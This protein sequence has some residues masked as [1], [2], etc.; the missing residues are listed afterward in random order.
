MALPRMWGPRNSSPV[1]GRRGQSSLLP[2]AGHNGSQGIMALHATVVSTWAMFDRQ[3]P[4][5]DSVSHD[6]LEIFQWAAQVEGILARQSVEDGED[7]AF[8]WGGVCCLRLGWRGWRLYW[9]GHHAVCWR[10]GGLG[11]PESIE[12]V[13]W[14]ADSQGPDV[15]APVE[16]FDCC[17]VEDA[18]LNRAQGHSG[19]EE[20][21]KAAPGGFRQT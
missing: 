11:C 6:L 17:N 7:M 12:E 21:K 16:V 4:I 19:G 2:Q 8:A 10:P 15:G 14:N 3:Q 18:H 1:L 9:V 13:F 5:E 20:G